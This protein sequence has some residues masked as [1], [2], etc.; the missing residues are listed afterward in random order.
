MRSTYHMVIIKLNAREN[1]E[2]PRLDERMIL[3]W[4]ILLSENLTM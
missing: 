3:K 1:L 4:I 2:H